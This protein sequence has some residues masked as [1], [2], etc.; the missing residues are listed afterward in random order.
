[1]KGLINIEIKDSFNKKDDSQK[2]AEDV[3]TNISTLNS[4]KSIEEIYS[5][6]LGSITA[7]Q[8]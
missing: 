2:S 8:V 4:P 6:S 7:S 5:M 1:M 3:F